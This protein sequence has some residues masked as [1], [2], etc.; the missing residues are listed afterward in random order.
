MII[1]HKYKFI[2]IKTTKT[3][4]T[5]IEVYLSSLCDKDDVVT[6]I[7]PHV[8]PHIS[9][10]YKGLYNPLNEILDAKGKGLA[11]SLRDF[12]IR[13]KYYNHMP[14]YRVRARVR[15]DV[16]DRYFKFCVERNP[17]DRTMSHF[18]MLQQRKNKNLTL[19]QYFDREMYATNYP[20]YSDWTTHK[21]IVDKVLRYESLNQE[22]GGVFKYLGVPFSGELNVHAK[23]GDKSALINRDVFSEEQIQII[24]ST[25]ANEIDLLGYTKQ[26][27]AI[28]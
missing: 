24:G 10:N 17:W 4:G 23:L 2:F 26:S 25:C 9:R 14:A 21:V 22:L 7:F 16:W 20:I 27:G 18:S 11:R 13:H 15:V 1:S 12:S 5:S 19:K 3:A 8:E 6:P 28:D